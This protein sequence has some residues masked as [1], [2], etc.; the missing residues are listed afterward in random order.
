MPFQVEQQ[1]NS[2]IDTKQDGR[3]DVSWECYVTSGVVC[4]PVM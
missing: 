4:T 2:A 1:T 3:S